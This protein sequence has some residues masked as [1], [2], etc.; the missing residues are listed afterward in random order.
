MRQQKEEIEKY[1]TANKRR[2]EDD[3]LRISAEEE[4]V[5]MER[6]G[7]ARE[8]SALDEERREIEGVILSQTIEVE[9]DREDI[10]MKLMGV[11]AEIKNLEKLLQQ[12][13]EQ[14]KELK[15][16]LGVVEEKIGV[17]RKKY[18]RRL[19][20]IHERVIDLTSDN[21]AC[22][23]EEAII[24]EQRKIYN[25]DKSKVENTE[26]DIQNWLY[27]MQNEVEIT[28]RLKSSLDLIYIPTITENSSE[29]QHEDLVVLKEKVSI[30][31]TDVNI[32]ISAVKSA[33]DMVGNLM[34]E[35]QDIIEK[36]PILEA[37]K[38]A[39]ATNKRFKEAGNVAKTIKTLTT[40]KE[41]IAE[42]LQQSSSTISNAE[43]EL[44]VQKKIL[45]EA[46]VN[47]RSAEKSADILTF[48]SLL[49]K[50]KELRKSCHKAQRDISKLH[51]VDIS[52]TS[53]SITPS[54]SKILQLSHI[55]LS[56]LHTEL[57]VSHL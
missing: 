19:Q 33:K 49:L 10:E 8:E 24:H 31:E 15:Q 35:D 29:L 6:S 37:E 40:R 17:V 13:K 50:A 27:W 14:E 57:E 5:D 42:L 30:A 44:E 23:K 16:Q 32:A 22:K 34:D 38:K 7:V 36:L 43:Q 56:F 25:D 18:E 46:L 39:H 20:R 28:T 55:A 1:I 41:E 12:K 4:R 3:D 2:L 45:D 53:S 48:N 11:T 52:S 26:K 21:E 54:Q 51:P 9:K 47:L